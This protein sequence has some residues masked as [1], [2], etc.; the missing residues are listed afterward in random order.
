MSDKPTIKMKKRANIGITIF[1][2][3][4]VIIV[5]YKLFSTAVIENDFYMKMANKN[6]FASIAVPASR[7][8]ILS[9][10]DKILAQ[11]ATVFEIYIDPDYFRK[12]NKKLKDK[13]VSFLSQVLEIEENTILKAMEAENQ[14]EKLKSKVEKPTKDKIDEFIRE[15]AAFCIG[16]K[17]D[18]KRYYP[19]NSLASSVVGFTNLAGEGIIGIESFYEENLSGIDGIIISAKDAK[20][21]EMPYKYSKYYDAKN[22]D[23][24]VLTLDTRLQFYLEKYIKQMVEEHKVLNRAC[25]IIMNAKT[26]AIMAMANSS[27]FDLNNPYD[28]VDPTILDRLNIKNTGNKMTEDE[29]NRDAKFI[30]W[31]NKAVSELYEP[32]SVFKVI[33]SS[34]ALE[35]KLITENT[36]FHC[37][38]SI[39]VEGW[40]KP[41]NCWNTSGHGDQNFIQALTNSC[42]PAFIEI[43][44]KLG[45][46]KFSD[47][48]ASFGF[49][50]KTGIDLP[51]EAQSS[52][53]AKDVMSIVDLASASMGQASK[54]TPIQMITGYA[55]AINGGNLVKPYIVNKIIDSEGN[56]VKQSETVIKRQVISEETSVLIRGYLQDVVNN[57]GGGNAYIKGYKIG[58]K[59]GTSEKLSE[60][61]IEDNMK[62]VASYCCF[63]PA[64]DPEIIM[65]ILA[66]E[67][68]GEEYYGSLVAVPAAINVL[69]EA[70]PYLGYYPEYSK[71]ELANMEKKIPNFEGITCLEAKQQ[72]EKMG[73]NSEVVGEGEFVFAQ[74]PKAN[75]SIP[76]GGVVILYSEEQYETEMTTVPYLL[77]QD[78]SSIKSTLSESVLN[79]I[80]KGA[81]PD[82][83]DS[84]LIAQSIPPAE[85]VQKGTI[86]ELTFAVKDQSG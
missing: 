47:Y 77:D 49:T 56:I 41:I 6:Q 61:S 8:T 20:G 4:F 57:N 50:E 60:Y 22:G 72:L 62:Y 17:E 54:V 69:K 53:H 3:V 29:K 79:Y 86:I 78:W 40:P 55:A 5:V 38:G 70:L 82:R 58:G 36:S 75:N 73:I 83:E 14:Y 31:S 34:S 24:V 35:E 71:D 12:N 81:S 64:D 46:D 39:T 63:A 23:S 59:S 52:Y 76:I 66:D 18:T 19:Q 30:Q 80:V 27:E 51:A 28:L 68:S 37:D 21:N 10:D 65:L 2:F 45:I 42:N 67:P 25:G 1:V 26:G 43:G 11:S 85:Q 9:A 74:Y 13:I 16:I 7:G 48:F 32:G 84:K 44:Q 33:T 15:N